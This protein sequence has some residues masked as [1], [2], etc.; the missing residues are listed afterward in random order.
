MAERAQQLEAR[1]G[2]SQAAAAEEAFLRAIQN[3]K[4][5]LPP[6]AF[7]Q[8]RK[9]PQRGIPEWAKKWSVEAPCVLRAAERWRLARH[10][11]R[12]RRYLRGAAPP[13]DHW[14]TEVVRLNNLPMDGRCRDALFDLIS[15]TE[16]RRRIAELKASSRR[17]GEEDP[18]DRRVRLEAQR[19]LENGVRAKRD[20]LLAQDWV[21]APLFA[22]PLR[23]SREAFLVRA[24]HHW[25]GR[26]S[27]ARAFGY[28]PTLKRPQTEDHI[29]WLLRHRLKGESTTRIAEAV[30]R[31]RQTVEE[32]IASVARLLRLAPLRRK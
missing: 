11:P 21:L 1:R 2:D 3:P 4:Y 27:R 7:S 18:T 10:R 17:T 13:P 22:D 15:E 26:A 32:G 16:R 29:L 19:Y 25:D 31:S 12:I 6:E 8:L 20:D 30:D 9:L 5:G 23:E 14:S 28:T 24:S